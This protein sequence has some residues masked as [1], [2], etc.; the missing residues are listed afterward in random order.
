MRPY[1]V[2]FES[3]L[4]LSAQGESEGRRSQR[5]VLM[6]IPEKPA[7][8][9][10]TSG[11]GTE[12][13]GSSQVLQ[14]PTPHPPLLQSVTGFRLFAFIWAGGRGLSGWKPGPHK[15]KSVRVSDVNVDINSSVVRTTCSQ[16]CCVSMVTEFTLCLFIPGKEM[17]EMYFDFRLYRLWKTRQ[18][19]KLLDFEDFVWRW[20]RERPVQ[21]KSWRRRRDEG[22]S[23]PPPSWSQRLTKRAETRKETRRKR[24]RGVKRQASLCHAVVLSDLTFINNPY[25]SVCT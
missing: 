17:I 16:W 18:H 23:A 15:V 9:S 10:L 21:T 6:M 24:I 1:S 22:V 19:S 5:H 11:W 12:G 13:S 20:S 4:E 8:S 2:E 7:G 3:P 25:V 14:K